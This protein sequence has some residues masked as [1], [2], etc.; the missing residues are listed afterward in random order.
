M[1]AVEILNNLKDKDKQLMNNFY[2]IKLKSKMMKIQVK[3]VLKLKL[4]NQEEED[5]Q[6]MEYI[7]KT[8]LKKKKQKVKN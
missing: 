6:R 5:H 2:K 4:K 8:I 7:M 3:I 1:K